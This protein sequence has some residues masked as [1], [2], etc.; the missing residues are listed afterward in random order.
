MTTRLLPCPLI[1]L[2]LL[3]L[4][5]APTLFA[6]DI[7]AILA[8]QEVD[9]MLYSGPKD[10]RINWVIQNRGNQFANRAEFTSLYRNE[11]LLAFEPGHQLEQAPYAQYRN[12]FNL[13]TFWWP[14]APDDNTGWTFGIIK[15]L[16]DSIFLPWSD[17]QTGW[18]TFFSTTRYGGGG[19]AGVDRIARVGDGKMFGMGWETFLHE[20]GHT[21][22]GLLDEYSASGSW[23]N[24]QCWET[25]NT[26]GQL[27]IDNIPWRKWI[28]PGTPIPTPYTEAY[29]DEY[30]AFE[31]AMTNYFGCH[32][33]TAR[34]CFMGA[35][36]FGEDYGQALCGPCIQRIICFL[37]KYVHVI[38][39][40]LPVSNN[41]EVTGTETITF[42]V[43][44]VKPEPNTQQ[45]R[46]L[47]NGKVI[48]SQV[49]SV[50]VTFEACDS[51][52]LVFEVHDTNSLVRYDP[53]FEDIYPKPLQQRTW[54]INQSAVNSYSLA[55][56][57]QTQ[58]VDCHGAA[59]GMVDFNITG[60]QPPYS[61]Y[62]EGNPVSNPVANLIAGN[63]SF[64]LVDAKG[65][66]VKEDV[67]IDAELSLDP[68]ICTAFSNNNW[69]LSVEDKNYSTDDLTYLW[70]TGATSPAISV[71]GD[72]TYSVDITTASGCTIQ[73][74]ISL[75]APDMALEVS[76]THFPTAV[77]APTGKI[78]LDI[79][80][81]RA[82]YTIEWSEK[83]NQDL[84]DTNSN[85]IIS[86]GTT[87]GHEP[88]FAFD[89]NLSTK[90]LHAV[91][92]DAFIGY[93]FATGEVVTYYAITSADDV[94][95]RDP[96]NWQ[97]Q[98]SMNGTDWVVLDQQTDHLFSS[99]FERRGFLITNTT[100]YVYYRLYV[101]QNYGDIATQIQELEIAGVR[102]ADDFKPNPLWA[103]KDYINNLAAGQY[104]YVVKDANALVYTD[105]ISIT[106]AASFYTD[107]L[108]VIKNGACQVAVEMPNPDFDYYW[109]PDLEAS[110][111]LHIGAWFQP[112]HSGNYF[113]GAVDRAT[114]VLSS[115]IK[116]FAVS[117]A[118]L[119]NA[120]EVLNGTE[121]AIVNPV[122]DLTYAWYDQDVCGSPVHVGTTFTP[123]APGTY[124]VASQFATVL[125]DPVDPASI[126]GMIVRMDASDLNGDQIVD[127]PPPPTS[128]LYGWTFSNGNAWADGNWFAFRSNYQ[129]G[130][131]VADF[132]TIW[133]QRINTGETGY[134]TILLAYEENPLSFPGRAPFEGLSK[135][136]PKHTD[137]SQLY[138][139]TAPDR[140]INGSTYLNGALVD[141]LTTPNPME[142]CILGTVLTETSTNEVFYTDTHWEGKI[143]E[144]ILY[145]RA[146]SPEEMKGASAYLR[147]KWLSVADLE[148]PRKEL[149]W[150]G[151]VLSADQKSPDMEQISIYPNP[152]TGLFR[153]DGLEG[154]NVVQLHDSAGRLLK[155]FTP[156]SEVFDMHDLPDGLYFVKAISNDRSKIWV[157]AIFKM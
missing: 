155:Q 124:Y 12:F 148:S 144:I 36:G 43:D 11:L 22:P 134:Q 78:Y 109:F 136:I 2:L 83:T 42:S 5:S 137:A 89:N 153:I 90:W 35:G 67:S 38:E 129:N 41:I 60:G 91:S 15:A 142:F 76:D 20:F 69:T 102:S 92:S 133:L 138:G 77:D 157:R 52:E 24:G 72:G 62:L 88:Q 66:R 84:T 79:Q 27:E 116:G 128:S 19:G 7:N 145:D 85:Q 21:M 44:V 135:N 47:L 107:N 3:L 80:K 70:S 40:P 8:V 37:Y 123:P 46:W 146:L 97:F 58:N 23:S 10:N 63:Y 143:G 65:C 87:W 98:G 156:E 151:T 34:S 74:T 18:A 127:N 31:G 118:E 55:S 140:T 132:A 113:V 139:N 73:K 33:P 75:V 114:G 121:L 119:P 86:S 14:N 122:A 120:V 150:D 28:K 100:P 29:V 112:P 57:A 45:Y 64:D 110:R 95:Q 101:Q 32:R 106:Y 96:R 149:Y 17:D 53:K 147:T 71:T 103:N 94:P 108:K 16:R 104:R 4:F 61:I 51:Y 1:L 9:T 117:L 13:Y 93:R 115:D 59:S 26:T 25:P 6:Q 82:P 130:L 131:G 56:I 105:S 126:S 68:Q 39:N 49:E 54:Y 30:G 99:R 154:H 111:I 125:P 152:T 48:A 50:D 141:P 81:G